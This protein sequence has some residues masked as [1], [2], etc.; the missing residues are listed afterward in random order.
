MEEGC[1]LESVPLGGLLSVTFHMMESSLIPEL[2]V[3]YGDLWVYNVNNNY[4]VIAAHEKLFK[5]YK[6]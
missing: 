1:C 5:F 6:L 3:D 4:L 2:I